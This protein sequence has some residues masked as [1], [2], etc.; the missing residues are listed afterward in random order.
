MANLVELQCEVVDRLGIYPSFFLVGHQDPDIVQNLWTQTQLAYLDNPIPGAFKERL[1]LYLSRYCG[2]PYCV[3]RH[4]AWLMASH[5]AS[6]DDAQLLRS[7]ERLV[8]MLD[9]AALNREQMQIHLDRLQPVSSIESTDRWPEAQSEVEESVFACAVSVFRGDETSTACQAALRGWL[10]PHWFERL[11]LF[12]SFVR[13]AHFWTETHEGIKLEDDAEQM[14][15]RFPSL[16][17]WLSSYQDRVEQE[18]SHHRRIERERFEAEQRKRYQAIAQERLVK[19]EREFRMLADNVPELFAYINTHRRFRFANRRYEEAF[20]KA[21]YE[22]IGIPVAQVLG[23]EAYDRTI[24]SRLERALAGQR[25][26][27]EDQLRLADGVDHW[28]T[29]VFIPDIETGQTV[30]G[31]FTLMSDITERRELEKQVLDIAAEEGRRIGN[32]LHDEIGQE[33]T[34]LSMIADTLVTAMTRSAANELKIAEKIEA[35]IKRT[36]GQVRRLARGMNPVDVDAEGLMSALSEM[37]NRLQELYA[38]Q[39]S[40]ECVQPVRL[41]DNQVATQMYRI[42]QEATTNAVKHGNAKRISVSLSGGQDN[43]VLRVVD[44]GVGISDDGGK[45]SGMGLK[46][47]QYRAGIAGGELRIQPAS[48]G[49]TE[50]TCLLSP[51]SSRFTSKGNFDG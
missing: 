25:V 2:R 45:C 35:G 30:N 7:A 15:V 20:H 39:C 37:C 1:F 19:Q 36:L 23:E 38:V 42:A 21:R 28:I 40:F 31:V 49:G 33:L 12:L 6:E 22:I 34:G 51:R 44:D 43:A 47:M 17:N 50:V 3:A 46:I 8:D 4:A 16:A 5:A 14:L 9:R 27:F 24:A 41:R 26:A 10:R 11:V 48:H 18:L 32:D 29:A 13:T